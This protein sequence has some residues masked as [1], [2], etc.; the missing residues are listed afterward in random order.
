MMNFNSNVNDVL[1][2]LMNSDHV[3]MVTVNPKIEEFKE[4]VVNHELTHISVRPNPTELKNWKKGG[5]AAYENRINKLAW[6][7]LSGLPI[8]TIKLIGNSILVSIEKPTLF[9]LSPSSLLKFEGISSD[10]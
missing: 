9:H 2:K 5:K 6:K 7:H 8:F 10:R 1:A 3:T 4:F